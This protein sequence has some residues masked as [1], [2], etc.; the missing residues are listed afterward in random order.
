MIDRSIVLF[1]IVI[2]LIKQIKEEIL[3]IFDLEVF[4]NFIKNHFINFNDKSFI[5][6]VLVLR[7][8]EFNLDII[9]KNRINLFD[10]IREKMNNAK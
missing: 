4:M 7:K 3:K 2:T 9:E 8:F 1:K 6:Y 5:L 10:I